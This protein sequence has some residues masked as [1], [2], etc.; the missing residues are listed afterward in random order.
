VTSPLVNSSGAQADPAWPLELRFRRVARELHITFEDGAARAIPYELLRVESP[1]AET[2]GHGATRPP[3]PAGKRN[4]GVTGAE[5]VGRYAV[6][7]RFDDGHD[8]G[9]YSWPY[10][11]TL[12]DD[13]DARM[14]TYEAR[15]AELGLLRG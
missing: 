14:A 13:R 9:L 5:L 12:A 10:L 4:V 15:M 3:P 6:R 7:I 2:K 1:S 8:T 11:R